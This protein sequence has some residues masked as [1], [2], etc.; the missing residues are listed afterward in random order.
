[1]FTP[2]SPRTRSDGIVDQVVSAI[3]TGQLSSGD[4]LPPER[5]LAATC[6]VARQV[7]REAFHKLQQMG[8]IEVRKP[9]G[10]VVRFL[11]PQAIRAP[12]VTLLSREVE[13]VTNFLDVRKGLEG[14]TAARSAERATNRDLRAI[15]ATIRPLR[16]AA[17]R[18][19]LDAFDA[20]DVAFHL[21]VVQATHDPLLMEL[22]T[23]F[24]ALMWASHG[25][26]TVI[27]EA[28]DFGAVC[29]EHEAVFVAIR[30]RQPEA[31]RA[32]MARHIE[33]IR[34][35]IE[36]RKARQQMR[37]GGTR[38]DGIENGLQ[39]RAAPRARAKGHAQP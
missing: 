21:S 2:L 33:M 19:D 23:V 8:L 15:E 26:R 31:A 16:A 29:R 6:A 30:S 13:A 14:M 9:H 3:L 12:L 36:R 24:R 37:V 11:S 35:R 17:A 1:M 39:P 38:W 34:R 10:T 27:L 22:S 7:V 4:R 25:L 28:A 32:A 20:S 5:E 18:N